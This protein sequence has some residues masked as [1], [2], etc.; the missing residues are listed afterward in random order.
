ME[1]IQNIE[2]KLSQ[3]IFSKGMHLSGSHRLSADLGNTEERLC[4]N[5]KDYKGKLRCR[6]LGKIKNPDHPYCSWYKDKKVKL[7]NVREYRSIK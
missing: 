5:C 6:T 4:I 3:N 1:I 7:N 2:F